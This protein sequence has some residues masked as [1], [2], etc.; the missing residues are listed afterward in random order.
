M[1]KSPYRIAVY[2][3]DRAYGGPEEGGWW[4]DTGERVRIIERDF[5]DYETACAACRRCNDWLDTLQRGARPVSSVA[6]RGGRYGTRV[7]RNPPA[8]YPQHRPI[9]E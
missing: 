9:Y 8:F 6:Y 4:Y 2:E 7:F 3:L 1:A 5:A